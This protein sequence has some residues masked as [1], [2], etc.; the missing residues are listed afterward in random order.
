MKE[1]DQ[2]LPYCVAVIKNDEAKRRIVMNIM[3]QVRIDGRTA[4]KLCLKPILPEHNTLT[5]Y[6]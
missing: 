3:K 5:L 6:S 1:R 2:V 4:S